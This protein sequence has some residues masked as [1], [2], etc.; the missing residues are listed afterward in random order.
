MSD[1]A[2]KAGVTESTVSRV[3]A[4][5]SRRRISAATAAKVIAA[6]KEVR[7]EYAEV[8]RQGRRGPRITR[9]P[10]LGVIVRDEV[11]PFFAHL[12]AHVIAQARKHGY[13]VI[14]GYAAKQVKEVQALEEILETGKC[15][16]ILLLGDVTEEAQPQLD[17]MNSQVKV[18]GL[19][20]G[21]G[22]SAV[23]F[24]SSDNVDATEALLKKLVGLGH[25]R[26]AFITCR[27]DE[28]VIEREDAFKAFIERERENFP[29]LEIV[30]GDAI[31]TDNNP[32]GG[33]GAM[34]SL[35][36]LPEP[37]TAVV[38]GTDNMA[39]GCLQAAAE[40]D[41]TVPGYVSVVSYDG[42]PITKYT[43][44]ALYSME[45]Q[46]EVIATR[47][48]KMLMDYKVEERLPSPTGNS[49]LYVV[50]MQ[51]RDGFSV[52]TVRDNGPRPAGPGAEKVEPSSSVG[53]FELAPA[54]M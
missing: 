40:L 53:E 22:T 21:R 6:A 37:P 42:L 41:V 25:R 4:P 2:R 23:P 10:L 51:P 28:D 33:K 35:L 44:P 27:P 36:Q 8:A 17:F 12:L 31:R 34:K 54:P 29:G 15:E 47:G 30:R 24:I 1:V 3:F 13:E 26:I 48:V 19:C 50:A 52:G 45:Q 16:G 18:L 43:V 9:R 14:V 20:G 38:A 11:D 49:H 46:V 39:I 32:L 7:F 5:S